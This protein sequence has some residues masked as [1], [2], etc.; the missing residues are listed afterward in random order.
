LVSQQGDHRSGG[1][2]NCSHGRSAVSTSASFSL[3]NAQQKRSPSDKPNL[4]YNIGRLPCNDRLTL[5]EMRN[6]YCRVRRKGI[7]RLR[8]RSLIAAVLRSPRPPIEKQHRHPFAKD[9]DEDRRRVYGD[10]RP[11]PLA[12]LARSAARHPRKSATLALSTSRVLRASARMRSFTSFSVLI[13]IDPSTISMRTGPPR[14]NPTARRNSAGRLNRPVSLT[15]LCK[16]ARLD[17]VSGV[18]LCGGA[19]HAAVYPLRGRPAPAALMRLAAGAAPA[20]GPAA[21]AGDGPA[22][23]S[24]VWF[25]IASLRLPGRCGAD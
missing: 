12:S 7:D 11:F 3:V 20:P 16:L 4:S 1:L 24:R 13:A 22:C 6:L 15:W 19:I 17:R 23:R 25:N 9:R 21:A 8:S 5:S 18:C 10:H 2:G 14:S